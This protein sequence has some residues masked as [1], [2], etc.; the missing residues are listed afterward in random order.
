MFILIL[1]LATALDVLDA[2]HHLPRQTFGFSPQMV[3]CYLRCT[4]WSY[5]LAQVCIECLSTLHSRASLMTVRLGV[6]AAY[7]CGEFGDPW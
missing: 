7:K 1:G 6:R 4:L 5:V 2:L 3:P